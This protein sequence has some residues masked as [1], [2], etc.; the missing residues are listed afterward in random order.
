MRAHLPTAR[1]EHAWTVS[2]VL[3]V[4]WYTAGM[5]IEMGP[6]ELTIRHGK[7]D[8]GV[9]SHC[10][11]NFAKVYVDYKRAHN[12]QRPGSATVSWSAPGEPIDE[13]IL[14]MNRKILF[15]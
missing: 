12:V 5:V 2:G 10:Q 7:H 3:E 1:G 8:T 15:G 6:V 11:D 14:A 9:C 4:W 13:A